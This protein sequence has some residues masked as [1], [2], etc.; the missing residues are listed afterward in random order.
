MNVLKVF[1]LADNIQVEIYRR[2]L[3]SSALE[4]IRAASSDV[5]G[6][7]AEASNVEH[8]NLKCPIHAGGQFLQGIW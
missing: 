3:S 6:K 8:F 5:T 1:G 7:M 2:C 4:S